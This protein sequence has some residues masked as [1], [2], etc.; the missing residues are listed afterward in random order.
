MTSVLCEQAL[1]EKKKKLSTG[2]GIY[3]HVGV[4]FQ[5]HV[6]VL[7]KEEDAERRHLFWD[8]A[9]LR[10]AW[11]DTHCPYYA[12]DGGMVRGLQSLKQRDKKD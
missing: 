10:D 12:L 9:W 11:D 5:H 6:L 3:S 4:D 8:T 1:K 2:A 7:I